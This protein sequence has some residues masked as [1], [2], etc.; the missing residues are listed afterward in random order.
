MRLF[1]TP[2][3]AI[4]AGCLLL[5]AAPALAAQTFA[6]ADGGKLA[7]ETCGSGPEAIVLL[8]D[9]ILDSSAFDAAWPRLCA[10][11][12]VVRY[13]RRGYGNSPAATAPYDAV[14]DLSAVMKAAGVSRAALVGSSS[15]G[16]VAVNFALAHPEAVDRLVLVGAAVNGFKPT[17]HFIKRTMT[18]V[19]LMSQGRIADAARDPYILTPAAD[20]Q[21][22]FVVADLTAHP[23]NMGAARMIKDGPE[24]MGRLGEIKVPTLII[25]G[26]ID[27][28]DVHA[29]AGALETLIPGAKRIVMTGG[30]HFIYLE[31]PEAFADTVGAF[32][33]RP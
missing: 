1:S 33:D 7:Y 31:R 12:K 5:G 10:R 2:V 28:P 3:A 26:E 8:H 11:F 13:D 18:L 9:G 22:A 6:P 19:T 21:R 20:A 30:G 25:T 15:G 17:E 4:A 23:G 14:A 24:V 27:I 32:V 16:G 29:H